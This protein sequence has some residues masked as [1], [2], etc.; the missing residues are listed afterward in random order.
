MSH[1]FDSHERAGRALPFQSRPRQREGDASDPGRRVPGVGPDEPDLEV[2][3]EELARSG[4]LAPVTL[5]L[6][7]PAREGWG[8]GERGRVAGAHSARSGEAP[9]SEPDRTPPSPDRS[10]RSGFPQLRDA[11]PE[12]A[13]RMDDHNVSLLEPTSFEAEQY[14][15]LRH[16]LEQRRR[17]SGLAVVAVTSPAPGDG[18][19]TTAINLAGTLAQAPEARVLL[20]DADLRLSTVEKE[21]GLR[22]EGGPGLTDLILDPSLSLAD[23]VRAIP[24][25]HLSVLTAGRLPEAPYEVL[26]SPRLGELLQAARVDYDTVVLDTP[27]VLPIPDCRLLAQWVD[28]FLLVVAAH[29]TPQRLVGEAL[30]L[31]DRSK[32]LG[33]VFN[34][35]DRPL[36]GYYGYRSYYGRRLNG[37][38]RKA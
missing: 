23:G 20:V 30:N 36:S 5:L 18:K 21:L 11:A 26:K 31:L 38:R 33:I 8:A 34:R 35:D 7:V 1:F 15:G 22:G 6:P 17:E 14:R 28:G 27:P 13:S 12:L 32:I 3:L 4:R 19:T 9:S 2:N 25:T 10:P 16:V 29:R 37:G 24:P